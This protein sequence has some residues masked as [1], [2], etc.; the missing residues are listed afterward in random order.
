MLTLLLTA[1]LQGVIVLLTSSV[2]LLADTIHNFGD[3]ATA[4]PLWVAFSMARRKTS[5]RFTYGYGRLEDVAGVLIVCVMLLSAGFSARA[6]IMAVFQPHQVHYP[7]AV[8]VASFLG[9]FGNELVARDR[10]RVGRDIGS[11]ALIADG[12][13]ARTDGFTS[14]A[15]L[16][17]AIGV[18]L[19]YPQVDPLVGLVITAVILKVVWD[20]A[21]SLLSR[22][23]D[24][25]DPEVVDEVTHAAADHVA[26]VLEVTEV[27]V[28]WLGHRM[29]ADVNI[30][31]KPELSVERGHEIAREVRHQLLHHLPYLA[32]ATIHVDP[33]NASGE[34]HH[35]IA[36]HE[37]DALPTHS[38]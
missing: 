23:L 25:I 32:N 18:W 15:V 6:A 34:H 14:L 2:A 8:A 26:D 1:V 35:R 19:G 3:A 5:K 20:T 37:H 10:I 30:T 17:T 21:K 4:I 16:L 33:V 28:R 29:L 38:H 36:T 22:L 27:R 12:Y 9:F 31:V 7:L 11:A 13:H 24:G